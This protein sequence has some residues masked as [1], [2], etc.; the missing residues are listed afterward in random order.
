[1]GSSSAARA[2]LVSGPMAMIVIV[3]GGW[4]RRVERI[5]EGAG[6]EVGVKLG[7]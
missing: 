4:E 1:M 7:G 6:V 3:S 2:R 5:W